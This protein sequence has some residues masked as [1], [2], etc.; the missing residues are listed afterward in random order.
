MRY[1]PDE[2]DL[3]ATERK[4]NALWQAIDRARTSGDWRPRQ[5]RL[6]DWCAYQALCPVFGGTPPPLPEPGDRAPAA[7]LPPPD[8]QASAAGLPPPDGQ[9]P[10]QPVEPAQP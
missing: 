7:G 6:C 4:I 9:I 10:A 2:G 3:L 8:G 5:S 1:V